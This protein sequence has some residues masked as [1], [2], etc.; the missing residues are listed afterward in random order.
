M[1]LMLD[2]WERQAVGTSNVP[3]TYIQADMAYFVLLRM[4]GASVDVLCKVNGGY[5]RFVT[6]ERGKKVIYL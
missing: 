5:E 6:E 1:T 3:G 4:V 2:A